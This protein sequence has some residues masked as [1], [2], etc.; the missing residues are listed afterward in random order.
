MKEWLIL[1]SVVEIKSF[2]G[3]AGYYRRFVQD[4]FK[5]AV[6]LT[7]FIRKREKYVWTSEC[8]SAFEKLKNKLISHQS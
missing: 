4:F 5:I 8:A 1:K 2:I 3:L 6:P 7:K